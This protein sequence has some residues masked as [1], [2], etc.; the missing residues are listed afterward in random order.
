MYDVLWLIIR[1]FRS[2]WDKLSP[3]Q[4]EEIKDASVEAME[5]LFRK[6]WQDAKSSG[7]G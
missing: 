4:K 1:F 2:I 3:E 5:W 6:F 7:G